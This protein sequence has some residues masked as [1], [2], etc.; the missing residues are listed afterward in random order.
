MDGSHAF[1]VGVFYT[2]ILIQT[3]WTLFW[4]EKNQFRDSV[5]SL[6]VTKYDVE[7]VNLSRDSV[8]SHNKTYYLNS[9]HVNLEWARAM[10]RRF[11][12]IRKNQ[13]SIRNGQ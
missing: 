5:L 1:P 3:K 7:Y 12:N 13:G 4:E 11:Y 2:R 8:L 6:L 10:T 9:D